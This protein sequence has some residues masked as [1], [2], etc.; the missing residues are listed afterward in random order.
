MEENRR[1][2]VVVR[3]G[4]DE[5][6]QRQ[7][8][9]MLPRLRRFA[10][11]LT[12]NPTEADDLVQDTVERALKNIARWEPGTR[13]DSWMYRIAQNQFIDGLRRRRQHKS[14]PVEEAELL[15]ATEGER[16][17]EAKIM[18][19]RTM[20]AMQDL[21]ED[22]RVAVSLVLVE[23][24]GY[25]EAADILN[26]PIGTLTSRLARGRETLARQLLGEG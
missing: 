12:G 3:Y 11:S 25:Q 26:I 17:T 7:I 24:F 10:L 13:L 6:V 16:A 21:P 1:W 14:V 19:A 8:V 22:Q 18:L 15:H 20:A 9:D 5:T 23:G 4:R 2:N